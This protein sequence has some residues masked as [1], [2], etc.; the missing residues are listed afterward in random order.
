MNAPYGDAMNDVKGGTGNGP[1]F[2]P[3]LTSLARACDTLCESS[4]V[5][6][7]FGQILQISG[8]LYPMGTPKRI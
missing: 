4:L 8:P 6:G 3:R 7:Q 5:D 1:A 2:V